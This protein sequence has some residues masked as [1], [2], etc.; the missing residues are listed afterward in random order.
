MMLQ[1]ARAED[2]ADACEALARLADV[3]GK[4]AEGLA[5]HDPDAMRNAVIYLIGQN[6]TQGIR[7]IV[8]RFRATPDLG[9]FAR[10]QSSRLHQIEGDYAAA[11]ADL[12][13]VT[14]RFPERAAP[15]W[16]IGRAR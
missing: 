12:E 15:F 3:P 4:I 2:I 10:V 16:W 11:L 7:E 13:D 8:D 5:A 9:V 14:T 6:R 1:P